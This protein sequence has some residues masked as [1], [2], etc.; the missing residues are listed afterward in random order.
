MESKTDE[1]VTSNNQFFVS[2]TEHQGPY[3]FPTPFHPKGPPLLG[4]RPN[5]GQ[6]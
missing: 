6:S 4:P 1:R 5:N 3:Q 2:R